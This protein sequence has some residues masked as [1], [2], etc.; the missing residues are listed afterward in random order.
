VISADSAL[1]G[2]FDY[3]EVAR[4]LL[5]AIAASYAALDL[6]GRATP[7][8]GRIRLAWLSGGAIAMG[9]GIWAMHFKG[10]MAFRLPLPV[11]YH[12]PTVLASL[13]VA[14]LA[15]A[16]ALY[17]ASRQKMG[18]VE[19]LTGSVI[20]GS[21]LAGMHYIGMAAMRLPAITHFSPVRVAC[22]I[23]LAILFSAITLLLAF[24]LREETRWSGPRRLG[25][26]TVIGVA[27]SAIH[28]TGLAAASFTPASPPDLFH[29]VSISPLGNNGIVIA[30]L[31]VLTAAIATSSVDRLRSEERLRLVI[32]TLPAMVW[33]KSPDGSADFLNQRFLEYTGLSVE[34][35][36]GWGWMREFHP[37]E[38]AEEEWRAA[39]AAGEPFE[40]EAKLR[41]ADGVYRRFLLRAEPVRDK[42]GNISKWYGTSTDIE[43]LKRAEDELQQAGG[44]RPRD[45]RD[46]DG[47]TGCRNCSRGK[48]TAYC[49]RHQR[50][51]LFAPTRG[52]DLE[53]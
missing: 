50:P 46:C 32:D 47:R 8:R 43:D 21:G 20:L 10:M 37:E 17:I 1:S 33:S 26:A 23:L 7:A 48:P 19:V 4:S 30:T 35:G 28:Y 39:F 13:L 5:I 27:V 44:S 40:R 22:S 12:W 51:I 3:G 31:T 11:E 2:S 14:I 42:L 24:S 49:N 6:L 38:R 25:S 16:V 52:W 45:P 53:S 34:E 9:L 36:L 18:P 29:A 41:R 15:S